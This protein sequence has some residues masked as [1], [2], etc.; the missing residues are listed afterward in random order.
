MMTLP[1]SVPLPALVADIGGTNARF[2]MVGRDGSLGETLQFAH[3]SFATVEDALTERVLPQL[4]EPPQSA[5]FA[6]AGAVGGEQ[7]KLTNSPWRIAPRSLMQSY[8]FRQVTLFNDFEA[9]AFSLPDL[10]AD[11]YDVISEGIAQPD[12]P[13]VVIG[14]GTGLGVAALHRADGQWVPIATEGG[15]R[16]LG[17]E[18]P[19][20]VEL[21][22]ALWR[23][24]TERVSAET[25]LSGRGI[26]RIYN[27]VAE[28]RGVAARLATPA[29]VSSAGLNGTD[30]VATEALQFFMRNL[31]RFVADCALLFRARGA[32]YLAGGVSLHLAPLFRGQAFHEAF[33]SRSPQQALLAETPLRLITHPTP[34]LLGVAAYVRAPQRF[35]IDPTG[36]WW[37]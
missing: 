8:G 2:A 32:V 26:V 20:E 24:Q 23:S 28:V 36:R 19:D 5:F 11:D 7:V 31:G 10:G 13:A 4:S 35:L 15:H 25:V 33:T 30:A 16:G 27:A 14:P 1:P 21:W 3:A 18:S 6:L 17:P 22:K 34:A 37:R 9:L 29:E 12:A